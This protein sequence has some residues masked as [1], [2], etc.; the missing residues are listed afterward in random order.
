MYN[1]S[2]PSSLKTYRDNNDR[3]YCVH[4]TKQKILLEL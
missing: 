3:T 4:T 1:N 2:V